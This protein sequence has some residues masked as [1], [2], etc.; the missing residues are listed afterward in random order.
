MFRI[1]KGGDAII[2]AQPPPQRPP[3][4]CDLKVS[5]SQAKVD[6]NFANYFLTTKACNN[7]YN[8]KCKGIQKSMSELER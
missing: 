2:R 4:H 8:V 6:K 7:C 5:R 3:S 1:K